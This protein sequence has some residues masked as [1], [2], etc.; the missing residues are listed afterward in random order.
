M[1]AEQLID[2]GQQYYIVATEVSVAERT[3]VLKQGET[4][5][6][7]NDFGDI[8]AEARTEE[9]LY[10]AGTRFLSRLK[11]TLASHRPLLLSSTIRRDNVVMTVDLTNPD[12]YVAGRVALPRGTLHINRTR[13][14]WHEVC[15]ELIRVRNFALATVAIDL[16]LSFGA[17]Y[18]DIFEVR[19]QRRRARGNLVAV[20]VEA[21]RAI[22]AYQG[23]D[24]LTRR[25]ILSCKPAPDN[26]DSGRLQFHLQLG[27]RAE[28]TIAIAMA[29]ESG[30]ERASIHSYDE[31]IAR[32]QAHHGAL[33]NLADRI[34][35]SNPQFN[36]WLRCSAADLGMMLTPTEHGLYPYAGVPWFDTTFGRDGILSALETLWLW[37][38]VSRG[39]LKFLARTQAVDTSPERDSEPG[40]ILH[41]ARKGEM[42][43]LGEIPFGRYYGSV[44]A[45]P[46]FVA[47]AG[48]YLR[49]TGDLAFIESLW[50]N[51][52]AALEWIDRHGDI[53]HD[54]FVEYARRAVTGLVHQGWKDSHDSIFH[55]DGRLAEGPIALCEV[56][57]YV[58]AARLAASEIALALGHAALASE[59]R[60]AARE[61][62]DRFEAQFW[63]DDIG[64]YALALDGDKRPCAVRTSNPGHCLFTGFVAEER[65]R[66]VVA[67]FAD[68]QLYS[69]WGLRTVAENELRYNPMAYHNGSVWPHDNA[70]AAAGAA[71][72]QCKA[73]TARILASQFDAS[74]YFEL[75][76]L[77][78]L[79]CGFRRRSGEAPTRYPVACSPQAWAAGAV[80]M[81]LEACLGISIDAGKREIRLTHPLLP[82]AIDEV[83]IRGLSVADASIDLTLHRYAGSVGVGVERRMGKLEV[84][85]NS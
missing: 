51:V 22:L 40:K 5:A 10:H 28:R 12:L 9:G 26:V 54:G 71:R 19:G 85:V 32:A 38:D 35:T 13:H 65:A 39:V 80:F 33:T 53:D 24:A 7:F 6:V 73:F 69:G 14:I 46:L 67:G 59:L 34:E 63:C 42:A 20:Q 15:Y 43:A 78:E 21:D 74:T 31:A 1:A 79:F 2:A 58:Y 64:M 66:A 55:T 77:P 45:T 16:A 76:R 70:I 84:V 47:L 11:L 25:T 30:A 41:E 52:Q 81:L 48:A 8:D 49:R 29:C 3:Y 68:E 4:F 44:D 62:R 18:A 23:L 36:A 83:R 27:S 61:L 82:D 37:P 60:D 56:Q 17:D 75:H 72:Y 57:G 50:G